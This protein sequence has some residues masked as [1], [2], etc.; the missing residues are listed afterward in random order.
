[1]KSVQHEM[2]G[3]IDLN[4]TI[5]QLHTIET[6]NNINYDHYHGLFRVFLHVYH[7]LHKIDKHLSPD[8]ISSILNEY[9]SNS[10]QSHNLDLV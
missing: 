5:T 2:Y 9:L 7:S 6:A 3:D 8:V 10:M 4:V 1:M